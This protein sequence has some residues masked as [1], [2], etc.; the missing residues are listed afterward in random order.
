M[1]EPQAA[2]AE[3]LHLVHCLFD[4]AAVDADPLAGGHHARAFGAAPT[5][6]EDLFVRIRRQQLE[7]FSCLPRVWLVRPSPGLSVWWDYKPSVI[8]V[9]KYHY[10]PSGAAYHL[11]FEQAPTTSPRS[12]RANHPAAH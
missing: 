12:P 5:V 4:S 7:E 10:E 2:K 8:G 1:A 9:E 3:L 6:D 11:L